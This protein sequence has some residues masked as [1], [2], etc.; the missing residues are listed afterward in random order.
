ME[1][2]LGT[3]VQTDS[4]TLPASLI[5]GAPPQ[6]LAGPTG[7]GHLKGVRPERAD[8]MHNSECA[9]PSG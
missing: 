1:V 6:P 8:R 3:N 9:W 5:A 2:K 4:K 7:S